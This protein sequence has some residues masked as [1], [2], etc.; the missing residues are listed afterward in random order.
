LRL[1]P[2]TVKQPLLAL[3]LLPSTVK[4]PLLAL[5]LLV[6]TR[7]FSVVAPAVTLLVLK[8]DFDVRNLVR[9]AIFRASDPLA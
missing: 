1:L 2:S 6:D 3:R 4:Q 8:S 9:A 7:A 5:R